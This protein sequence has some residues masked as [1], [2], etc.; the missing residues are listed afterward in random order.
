MVVAI[1]LGLVVMCLCALRYRRYAPVITIAEPLVYQSLA[2]VRDILSGE[3]FLKDTF[4]GPAPTLLQSRAVPNERL[5]RAFGIDN[6][7][8]TTDEIYHKGFREA[9]T[10][11]V[12]QNN[13][14]MATSS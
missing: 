1:L 5:I 4:W 14:G 10:R 7:F 6:A 12:R 8:T 11:L 2:D 13:P 9:A 3:H